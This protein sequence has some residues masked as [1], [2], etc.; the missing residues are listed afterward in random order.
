MRRSQAYLPWSVLLASLGAVQAKLDLN[1]DS[2]I[3]VYWGRFSQMERK[4]L[5][6]WFYK[7]QNSLQG[8]GGE[9]QQPLAH[10]C[11]SE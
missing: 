5:A 10:Y 9:V 8:K 7:G 2:N 1:S 6:K 3:V 11:E 4:G